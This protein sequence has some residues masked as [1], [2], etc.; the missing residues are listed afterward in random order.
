MD[1]STTREVTACAATQ[2]HPKMSWNPKVYY[3]I[4]KNPSLVPI[5]SQTKAG[6]NTPSNLSTIHLYI[7]P[8]TPWSS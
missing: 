7:H 2:E 5:L 3:R 8:P 1:L 6:H 4:Y